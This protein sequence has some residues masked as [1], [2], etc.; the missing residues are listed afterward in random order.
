MNKLLNRGVLMLL[1]SC[2]LSVSAF[3]QKDDQKEKLACRDN[4]HSDKLVSHC[5][6]K[7]ETLPASGD[8]IAVDGRM[9]GGVS[10]K[11][12]ERN[13]IL[14]RAQI[15]TAA[16]TEAEANELTKQIKIEAAGSKIFASGPENRK[17]HW[18]SVSYEIFVPQRSNLSLKTNNGGISIS[19][20]NGRLE[21]DV[22]FPLAS[23]REERAAIEIH[24]RDATLWVA[25]LGPGRQITLPAAPF[26]HVFIAEGTA[27][28][29]GHPPLGT[30]DA[31]RLVDAGAIDLT[32]GDGGAHVVVWETYA[33]L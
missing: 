30:G 16:P 22:L 10:I 7:E 14:M 21:P 28:L 3:A 8:T 17:D 19:D 13:Q 29:P 31:A 5:E 6:I 15:Q 12:W 27:E 1:M 23:G 25:R 24:Q 20:V 32:A 11:G 18:W 9:N 33:T 4:W 26:V 2:V